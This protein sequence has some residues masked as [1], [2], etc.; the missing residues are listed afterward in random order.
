MKSYLVLDL[1][2]GFL[3][4]IN[5]LSLLVSCWFKWSIS[6]WFSFGGLYISS[7]CSILAWRIPWIEEPG[8][9]QFMGSQRIGHNWVTNTR[10][11]THT[12]IS[13]NMLFLLGWH[14]CLCIIVLNIL[15]CFCLSVVSVISPFP[16]L[17]LFGFSVIPS[18]QA[19]S[20]VFNF[21]YP[22]KV[23]AH[24]FIDLKKFF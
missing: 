6:S 2:V 14:I 20:E 11:H 19:W 5:S 4:I 7:H 16:F 22:F 9:L 3:K 23:P 17:I 12:H 1:F 21:V 8:G 24:G 15:L 10:T 13:W 18:W